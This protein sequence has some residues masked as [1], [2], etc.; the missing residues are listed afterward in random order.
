MF[1]YRVPGVYRQEVTVSAQPALVTGV[2]AFVGFA[3]AI[4]QGETAESLASLPTGLVFPASVS[5]KVRAEEGLLFFK[6]PMTCDERELL[7]ALSPDTSFVSA[8]RSL[9]VKSQREAAPNNPIMLQR[10]ADFDARFAGRAGS[11]LADAVAAFFTNGG[12]R[13]Y[14]VRADPCV[15]AESALTS[16]LDSLAAFDDLDLV[17]VPDAMTL[18]S[19][20]GSGNRPDV[21]AIT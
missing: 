1:D 21:A 6:G 7:L 9:Y 20:D 12:A 4:N 15:D 18:R 3:D 8:V 13:C 5:D 17:A 2:P 10:Q 19:D 11:Y 16:A 14:V